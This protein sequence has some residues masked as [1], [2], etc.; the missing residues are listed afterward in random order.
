MFDEFDGTDDEAQDTSPE[1]IRVES[2]ER[3]RRGRPRLSADLPR[4]EVIHDLSDAEKICDEHGCELRPIGEATSEELEFQPAT[5][6]VL[7]HIRKKYACPCCEGHVVTAAKPPSMIPKSIATP[8]LLSWVVVS[9]YQDALPLYRQSLIFKR[10]G[11]T[12]D[13]TTL[14]NWMMACGERVQPLVNLLWDK[15]REQPVIHMDETTVQVLNEPGKTPES[16]S[17]MWVS[18]AGP[19][20]AGVV[21]FHYDKGRSAVVPK[22]LLGD[23]QGTLM[24]DGYDGY[25]GVCASNQLVRLGCWAHARRKFVAAQRQQPKGKTGAADQAVAWIGKLYLI[26]RAAREL[27]DEERYRARQEKAVPIL[28]QLRRWLEKTQPRTAPKTA[29]GK[30]LT[31]LGNQWTC[32]ERYVDEGCYPIDN[33]RAENAIR[34]FVIGRKNYLFSQ[35]VRGVRAN[36]NLYTLIETAKAHGLNP[37][38]YLLGV[39]ERLPAAN[40]V[41][42]FEALLPQHARNAD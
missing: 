19:P 41:E 23:Y 30:A 34:P 24:A 6:H 8:A 17:Y 32:L 25:N 1:P 36:A 20:D 2:H 38:A 18:T 15:L 7:K 37:H 27:T 22:T 3:K 40:C 11:V 5:L 13:R 29:L 10:L 9:K 16:K 12:L 31:Y 28:K 35:S 26:E 21:V 4:V 33:N 14:A 39:F 42:D